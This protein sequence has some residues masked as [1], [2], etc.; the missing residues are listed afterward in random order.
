MR[1]TRTRLWHRCFK[2][3][4][5]SIEC[6]LHSGRPLTSTTPK[7]VEQVQVAVNKTRQLTV[8]ELEEDL[9]ILWT[10]VS[11]ILVD[12]LAIKHSNKIHATVAVTKANRFCMLT[13]HK[14]SSVSLKILSQ[15]VITWDEL[16]VYNHN[17]KTKA[18]TSHCGRKLWIQHHR[19]VSYTHLDVYKRQGIP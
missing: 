11:V 3:D 15:K 2:N 6:D 13:L 19:P 12:D 14:I 18:Q 16:R 9:G 7:N 17:S 4:Q 10:C 1:D 8:Q 5:E